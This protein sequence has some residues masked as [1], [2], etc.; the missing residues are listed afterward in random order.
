MKDFQYNYNYVICGAGGYYL[1]GYHDVISHPQVC[2]HATHTDGFSSFI[3]K[4]LLRL[5]FSQV[6]NNFIHTPFSKYVNPRLYPHPFKRQSNICFIF[7]G[8]VQYIYQTCY[9]DYLRKTYPKAKLVLYMQDLVIQNKKLDFDSIKNK[10]DLLI[11][12]DQGDAKKHHMLFHPTPMSFIDVNDD[13]SIEESDIYFCGKA[14]NRYEDIIRIYNHC[15]HIGL[16]C[17]F[18]IMELPEKFTRIEGINYPDKL[19]DYKKNIQHIKKTRCILEIMQQDADGFTPRL[20]ESIMYDCHLLSNNN[21]IMQS[22]F[23]LPE[24]TH[25]FDSK[26]EIDMT[27]I[28]QKIKYPTELKESLSPLHLLQFIDEHLN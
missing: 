20:W 19:F 17:D 16:R 24:G 7:F 22:S 15:Q 23:Y 9:L 13:P 27:W 26:N 6:V 1:F 2:Y 10:F 3:S 8:G 21:Q 5:N 25:I 18:N 4:K 11:S 14:K 12:Y 28:K